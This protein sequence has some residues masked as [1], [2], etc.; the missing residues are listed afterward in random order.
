M[1]TTFL[2]LASLAFLA[3]GNGLMEADL[4]GVFDRAEKAIDQDFMQRFLN[5]AKTDRFV[6]KK[7]TAS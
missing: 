7:T 1:L 4:R 5:G 2:P 6:K 3:I